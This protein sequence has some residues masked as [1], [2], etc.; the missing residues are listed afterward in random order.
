MWALGRRFTSKKVLI[1]ECRYQE[2]ATGECHQLCD[3]VGFQDVGHGLLVLIGTPVVEWSLVVDGA[4]LRQ[5]VNGIDF[6]ARLMVP[7]LKLSGSHGSKTPFSCK[8]VVGL[9]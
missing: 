6:G 2:A 9:V 5:L 4:C 1:G 8:G 3:L 7:G